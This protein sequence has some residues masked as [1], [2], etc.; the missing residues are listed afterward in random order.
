MNTRAST[1]R[2]RGGVLR[3][4]G[5]MSAA[6]LLALSAFAPAAVFAADPI[7]P[8]IFT[9]DVH[10]SLDG[11][12]TCGEFE[13]EF[14]GGQDWNDAKLDNSPDKDDTVVTSAGT[15]TITAA[16]GDTFSWSSTFGID[17][18]FV[19]S[20]DGGDKGINVLYVY[21]A[22]ASSPDPA[23]AQTSKPPSSRSARNAARTFG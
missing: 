12:H 19:K 21:A 3:T 8:T 9:S 1:S 17:A 6:G 23:S 18:V 22:T 16:S 10:T 13:V 7:T 15:I 20:G 5:W 14:G 2:R 4:A 11:N